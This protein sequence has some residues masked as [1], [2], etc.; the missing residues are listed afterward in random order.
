MPAV[1][2]VRRDSSFK[3]SLRFRLL[4][5]FMA[6]L[7]RRQVAQQYNKP[8]DKVKQQVDQGENSKPVD[9]R[10]QSSIYLI[11]VSQPVN[12]EGNRCQRACGPQGCPLRE[13]DCFDFQEAI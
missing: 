6:S 12:K 9:Q 8:A 1:V 4:V 13:I 3:N 5:W 2:M 11:V 7:R 10:A